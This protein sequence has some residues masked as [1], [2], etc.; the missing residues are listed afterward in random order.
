MEKNTGQGS[1]PF[2]YELCHLPIQPWLTG[3]GL[4]GSWVMA[5]PA[6]GAYPDRTALSGEAAAAGPD[7]GDSPKTGSWLRQ[8]SSAT[9]QRPKGSN[10]F[11]ERGS[12]TTPYPEGEKMP[13]NCN[14]KATGVPRAEGRRQAEI[15]PCACAFHPG[16][17]ATGR[18]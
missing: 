13:Q 9:F 5:P 17:A 1:A 18:E 14:S 6:A 16:A 10:E 4:T 11:T 15:Q 12:R 7:L 3:A 2:H 8:E